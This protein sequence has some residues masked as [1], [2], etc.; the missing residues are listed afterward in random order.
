MNYYSKLH[1]KKPKRGTYNY[2]KKHNITPQK[3]IDDL[4]ESGTLTLVIKKNKL[5]P[6]D[7]AKVLA[8]DEQLHEAIKAAHEYCSD[9]CL[10]LLFERGSKGYKENVIDADGTVK[11]TKQT[12]SDH[13]CLLEYMKL[14]KDKQLDF[15]KEFSFE[16]PRFN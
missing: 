14:I 16:I 2:F 15:D 8:K 6:S 5:S 1:I 10:G 9:L 4:C 11:Q 7:F 13:R 3:F 12:Y